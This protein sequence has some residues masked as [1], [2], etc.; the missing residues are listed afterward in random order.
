MG[1]VGMLTIEVVIHVS[2]VLLYV[3][4]EL[5][6]GADTA[7][8]DDFLRCDRNHHGAETG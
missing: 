5:E 1:Y 3:P 7:C 4:S 6:T 8:D 2:M